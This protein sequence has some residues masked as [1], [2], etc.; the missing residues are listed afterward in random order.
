MRFHLNGSISSQP[1]PSSWC[2]SSWRTSRFDILEIGLLKRAWNIL[3]HSVPFFFDMW[4]T[5]L[6]FFSFF[7]FLII[8]IVYLQKWE[9]STSY[10]LI[11]KNPI[12]RLII[13]LGILIQMLFSQHYHDVTDYNW[14]IR[15]EAM[16][17][18]EEGTTLKYYLCSAKERPAGELP[19]RNYF[20]SK[21]NRDA[22]KSVQSALSHTSVDCTHAINSFIVCC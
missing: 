11:L 12:S 7:F 14:L 1:Y 15:K 2:K 10:S 6:L 21:P 13:H 22:E 17:K 18:L 5:F 19:L 16:P 4:S 8:S 20:F 3:S 9:E